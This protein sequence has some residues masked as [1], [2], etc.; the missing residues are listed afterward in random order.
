MLAQSVEQAE[1]PFVQDDLTAVDLNKLVDDLAEVM[2]SRDLLYGC[3]YRQVGLGD[4]RPY[5]QQ[6]RAGHHGLS[7]LAILVRNSKFAA[8]AAAVGN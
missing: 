8:A 6:S 3:V 1:E 2:G 7:Q 4:R 5:Y